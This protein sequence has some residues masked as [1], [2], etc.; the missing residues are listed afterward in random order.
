MKPHY[1]FYTFI[2]QEHMMVKVSCHWKTL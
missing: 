1:R 2:G